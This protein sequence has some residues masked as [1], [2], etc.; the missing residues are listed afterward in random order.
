LKK[1]YALTEERWQFKAMAVMD[2]LIHRPDQVGQVILLLHG[3]NERGRSIYRKLL[4]YLPSD[5]IIIAPNGPFP[6]PRNREQRV[7]YGYS[8]YFYDRFEAKYLINQDL[9]KSW[10]KEVIHTNKFE[11]F[12]LTIVGFSQ[13]GYLAPLVGEEM[14]QTQ[15]V[16]G[17]GCEF[18]HQLIQGPLHFKLAAIHG[19][20]DKI[21]LPQSA[22]HE[23][24]L[25][26]A[27]GIKIDW[28]LID[29]TAHEISSGVG[30][31][32]KK[33]LEAYGK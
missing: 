13:G 9:A 8:W 29:D 12:P 10:I 2:G 25:L 23:I 19:K 16:I 33:I 22:R 18:R 30:L 15:L 7:T 1:L 31:E 27:D 5:A 24:E 14:E 32:V 4:P 21:I 6:L 26:K 28:H 11:K 17:I 20:N 3:L